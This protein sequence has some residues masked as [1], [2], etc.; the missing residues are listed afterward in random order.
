MHLLFACA[1]LWAIK[2]ISLRQY[3]I[4]KERL[5]AQKKKSFFNPQNN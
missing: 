3:R 2:K 4:R 1:V 5:L